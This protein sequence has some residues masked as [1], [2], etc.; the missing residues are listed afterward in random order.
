MAHTVTAAEQCS[1]DALI[2]RGIPEST[3]RAIAMKVHAHDELVAALRT[4]A[5]REIGD[6]TAPLAIDTLKG[7][8]RA[9]LAK[10]QS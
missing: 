9:A 5:Y 10:V 7:I 8:A 6:P 2:T 3:A 4:I 1:I